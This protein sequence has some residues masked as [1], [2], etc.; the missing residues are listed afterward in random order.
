MAWWVGERCG[1]CLYR[2][3]SAFRRGPL[4][5]DVVTPSEQ[6]W[7]PALAGQGDGQAYQ[8]GPIDDDMSFCLTGY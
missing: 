3:V 8:G 5:P 4:R 6:E 1:G 7:I 2:A